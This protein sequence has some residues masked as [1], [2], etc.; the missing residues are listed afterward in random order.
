VVFTDFFNEK[1][2]KTYKCN[3]LL[4]NRPGRCDMADVQEHVPLNFDIVW[5]MFQETDRRFKE[6]AKRF[7]E[8]DRQIRETDK[9][10]NEDMKRQY[11]ETKLMIRGMIG[12]TAKELREMMKASFEETRRVLRETNRESARERAEL[13]RETEKK[14]KEVSEQVKETGRQLEKSK[15]ELDRKMGDLGNR[16]GELAEH[17]VAPSINEKFNLLGYH[18]DAIA[19]G[20]LRIDG[21]G[22]Q[23]LAEID[24]LLQNTEN[25]VAVEV[26][27]KLLER[28]VDE[29][30]K[31]LEVLRN[32]ADKHG[33]R[34]K[35]RGAMAGAIVSPGVRQYTLNAGLYVIVQ[36]GDTVKIDIP[37][38]FV[39]HQW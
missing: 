33:D 9:K 11:T 17:L 36:T 31:R 38:G 24:L 28:H 8:T 37:E 34:R 27:S 20:G 23:T 15:Q 2:V 30:I 22:G 18:F 7:E 21:P 13:S 4:G 10:F 39:P 1:T 12:N 26:K 3:R 19:P 6:T 32:W 35:I 16:F 29:H 25:M 14:I 5:A